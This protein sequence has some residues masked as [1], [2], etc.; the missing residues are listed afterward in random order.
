MVR[1]VIIWKLKDEFAADEKVKQGIKNGLE[2][3]AGKIPG[4]KE[5]K[6]NIVALQSSNC[7][8]M[9]DS[10]FE[11][12]ESLKGY[13]VHPD[14][15]AVAQNIVGPYTASRNCFDYEV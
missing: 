8:V 9:L 10:L 2:G 12:E 11:D 5:I 15:V 14:H 4:L 3:L 1:H 6:V 7:E 13:A